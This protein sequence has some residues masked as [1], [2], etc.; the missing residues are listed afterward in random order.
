MKSEKSMS[1]IRRIDQEEYAAEALE[2]LNNEREDFVRSA[3]SSLSEGVSSEATRGILVRK[4]KSEMK[5]VLF[6]HLKRNGTVSGHYVHRY[7]YGYCR[8][9]RIEPRESDVPSK[10]L[11]IEKVLTNFDA[12]INDMMVEA[13]K[14][15]M[16]AEIEAVTKEAQEKR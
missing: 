7:T 6:E 12:V 8:K 13:G 2:L 16:I 11:D 15:K 10:Y 9:V 5:H 1:E 4:V 14:R 3:C